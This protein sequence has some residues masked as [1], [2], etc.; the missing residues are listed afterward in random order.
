M[1]HDDLDQNTKSGSL[2]ETQILSKPAT[3]ETDSVLVGRFKIQSLQGCGRF[4]CVYKATDLQLDSNVAIKVLHQHLV[5]EASLRVFKNEI[6]TLRQ[7]SHPNIVRVHEYYEDEHIHFITMDWIQGDTLKDWI[8]QH[9]VTEETLNDF[10][11]Q[12][13]SALEVTESKAIS[14]KDLK[15]ENILIDNNQHLYIADFGIASAVGDKA[16]AVITGTPLY[17]PPEYLE[18]GKSVASIDIYA[19]GL[20]LYELITKKLPY[21]AQTQEELIKEKLSSQKVKFEKRFARYEKLVQRCIAPLADSRPK[22]ASEARKLIDA[23][24]DKGMSRQSK[25]TA[26][27]VATVLLALIASGLY[28]FRADN[29]GGKKLIGAKQLIEAQQEGVQSLAVLPFDTKSAEAWLIDGLPHLLSDELSQI[30]DLRIVGYERSRETMDLLGYQTP[31]DEQK[32]KVISD[33]TQSTYLLNTK[34]VPIGPNR[35]QVNAELIRVAGNTV[36]TSD[37]IQFQSN[38]ESLAQEF[39]SLVVAVNEQFGLESL[40]TELYLPQGV[41]LET[42]SEVEVLLKNGEDARAK[43][44]LEKLLNSEA[45]YS[46]GWLLLGQLE[47]SI[48]SILEAESAFQKAVETSPQNSLVRNQA[49]A[50]LQLLA[51]DIDSAIE[52]YRSILQRL[53]N[54]SDI[55]LELAQLLIQQQSL[56]TAKQELITVVESD[57][58]HPI[59]W[60]E[61]SKVA[62]WQGETQEA[63]D[64]YLVKALV[65]AKKLKNTQLQGDVLNAFGVAHHRLGQ[66]DLALD[67]YK[68]GLTDRKKVNDSRGIVTSLSNLASVY[69]VKGEYQQAEQNLLQ[70]LETNKSR[71]D[72][73]KQADLFNELGVIAEEQGLYSKALEHFQSSLSIRMKLD[74]DWLK[75]ESL[76]NVAY[77]FFLLSDE[78]QATI[79]WEQAKAY[80]EKVDDPVGVVRVNENMAQLEL[81]KG[82]WQSAYRMYQSALEKSEELN[83][84]EETIVAQ[85]YLAKIAFLQGNFEQPPLQLNDIKTELKDRQDVRGQVEFG[86]WLTD[87]S[88]STGAYQQAES[89]LAELMPLM[90]QEKNRSQQLIYNTLASRLSLYQ[91][92]DLPIASNQEFEQ[93]TSKAALESLVLQLEALLFSNTMQEGASDKFLEVSQEFDQYDLDLHRY[94][95][96]RKLILLGY[97]HAQSGDDEAL[98]TVL[99]QLTMLKRG[100][101]TYW[102]NYQIERL[103]SIYYGMIKNS[104]KARES[105]QKALKSFTELKQQLPEQQ[106][107]HIISLQ[108]RYFSADQSKDDFF[109]EQVND[110]E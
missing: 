53:P 4:G 86:L 12:I 36:E 21:H 69:A 107:Q 46:K 75:A 19:F 39:S 74:D 20:I 88:I 28:F 87:W 71:N 50:E 95:L 57:E 105:A 2:K 1:G 60:Y 3:L 35:Y 15:P 59:A 44:L 98:K 92:D 25:L 65:T 22:T 94:F 40:D 5:S 99:D 73:V 30:S 16:S 79:Y 47:A 96:L 103:E 55:R 76:N 14:H 45:E 29:L 83:L 78:E 42:I 6:L 110:K 108:G 101:G 70:A 85:A 90:E 9:T 34:L 97:Y 43:E 109:M 80:Y 67:Y 33:L 38:K 51:G 91:G 77:I 10:T 93:V 48:G 62:I 17:S 58:N 18:S 7:L 37:I 104:E 64:N 68:Q 32:L 100:V 23:S 13:L 11:G 61:L 54:N 8:E 84:T 102:R 72:A 27:S 56:E 82:N 31:L 89:I 66:L 106:Q 63:V 81:Q 49:Q 52:T 41:H 26:I 24:Q